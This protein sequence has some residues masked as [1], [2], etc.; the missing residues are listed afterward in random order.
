MR[1]GFRETL[2]EEVVLERIDVGDA[3]RIGH[4]RSRG[5]A[6]SRADRDAELA[7]LADEVPDHEKVAGETHPL[8]D[9]DLALEPL[10]VVRHLVLL[11]LCGEQ[12]GHCLHPVVE[13]GAGH[14]GEVGVAVLPLRDGKVREGGAL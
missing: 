13:A 7:R 4:Q 3:Q 6:A 12:R 9:L 2:E 10:P 11:P 14:L 8:D 5:G 1:S